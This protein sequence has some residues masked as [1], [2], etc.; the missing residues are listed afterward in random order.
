MPRAGRSAPINVVFRSK[1]LTILDDIRL[2]IPPSRFVGI[3]GPSGAGKSSLL[4]TLS[5]LRAPDSGSVLVDGQGYLFRPRSRSF[6]F[7]PAG[8]HRA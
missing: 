7:V 4:T 6:G 5:G 3:I 1:A 2:T 8:G